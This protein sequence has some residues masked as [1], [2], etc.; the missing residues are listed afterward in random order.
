LQK[1]GF[2]IATL[3]TKGS[4]VSGSR[5]KRHLPSMAGRRS[6]VHIVCLM[7]AAFNMLKPTAQIGLDLAS[8]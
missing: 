2:E 8:E 1:I 6:G 4:D 7:Y 3:R 5:Q